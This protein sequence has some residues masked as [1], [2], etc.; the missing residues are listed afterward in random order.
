MASKVAL[1]LQISKLSKENVELRME[2]EK[3]KAR[4]DGFSDAVHVERRLDREALARVNTAKAELDKRYR[5]M[6]DAWN[7]LNGASLRPSPEDI[8][9][10]RG[11]AEILGLLGQKLGELLFPVPPSG[12]P[13]RGY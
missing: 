13:Y 2:L 4:L 8:A 3:T 9:R 5:E 1:K 7:A 10:K 11:Q 12:N 6:T